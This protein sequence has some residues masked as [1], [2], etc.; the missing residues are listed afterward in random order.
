ML[1]HPNK[2]IV[3]ADREMT[4][5]LILNFTVKVSIFYVFLIINVDIHFLV[6]RRDG[7]NPVSA[8]FLL[9]V[10]I[11]YLEYWTPW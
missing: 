5:P 8:R 11:V 10:S 7:S 9:K 3:I 6:L 4:P 2:E 1:L